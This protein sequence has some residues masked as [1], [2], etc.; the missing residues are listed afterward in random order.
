[1]WVV[2]IS[3]L[4][5]RPACT[6]SITRN[7]SPFLHYWSPPFL[8]FPYFS[9]KWRTF[10]SNPAFVSPVSSANTLPHLHT[11]PSPPVSPNFI[12]QPTKRYVTFSECLSL[13]INLLIGRELRWC[14]SSHRLKFVCST[15]K[16]SH[17]LQKNRLIFFRVLYKFLIPFNA[18]G[19]CP[20]D[21]RIQFQC[22]FF[23]LPFRNLFHHLFYLRSIH[24]FPCCHGQLCCYNFHQVLPL[25]DL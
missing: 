12:P 4:M 1:M 25:Q 8:C 21:F 18:H 2:S 5:R 10:S 20:P 11:P 22:L 3:C 6:A 13:L 23:N 7:S 17:S 19:A 16:I 14:R 24:F 9:A 15:H